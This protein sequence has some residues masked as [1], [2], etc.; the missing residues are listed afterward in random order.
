MKIRSITY[1]MNPGWPIDQKAVDWAGT[2][3]NEA[4][5][6]F[7]AAGYEVQTTRLAT[8]P[9]PD[10]FQPAETRETI[11]F[12]QDLEAKARSVGYE[13]LSLGPALPERTDSYQVIP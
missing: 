9:F 4:R 1:F 13:Y 11:G 2:F 10:L 7:I 5:E 6:K 3:I 12:A 8:I